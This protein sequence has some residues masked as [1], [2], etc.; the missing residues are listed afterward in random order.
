MSARTLPGIGLTGFWD[1]ETGPWN[2]GMDQNLRKLSALVQSAVLAQVATLPGA[3]D[4][5]AMYLLTDDA[6]SHPGELA[7][8]DA[9]GWTY[10]APREGHRVYDVDAGALLVRTPAGWERVSTTST[11][12]PVKARFATPLLMKAAALAAFAAVAVG[13][14][15]EAGG[16]RYQRAAADATDHHV[17]T[18]AGVKFYVRPMGGKWNPLAFFAPTDGNVADGG[19][20]TGSDASAAFQA[21]FDAAVA[22]AVVAVSSNGN[23][24]AIQFPTG[25]YLVNGL[26]L[27]SSRIRIDATG[28]ELRSFAA[29]DDPEYMLTL[30]GEGFDEGELLTRCGITGLVMEGRRHA[31][32]YGLKISGASHFHFY[33]TNLRGFAGYGLLLENAYDCAFWGGFMT[34]CGVTGTSK[35]D[36]IEGLSIQSTTVDNCNQLYFYTWTFESNYGLDVAI[37]QPSGGSSFY[38]NAISFIGCK[39]EQSAANSVWASVYVPDGFQNSISFED[40]CY[41]AGYHRDGGWLDINLSTSGK[42]TISPST[43]FGY[44]SDQAAGGSTGPT[45]KLRGNGKA[46]IGGKLSDDRAD[47]VPF[48]DTETK[49]GEEIQFSDVSTTNSSTGKA[50]WL[51]KAKDGSSNRV[52]C[53]QGQLRWVFKLTA[54]TAASF[55]PRTESGLLF[56]A[57][58]D[59]S[60]AMGFGGYRCEGGGAATIHALAGG[61]EIEVGTGA[62]TTGAT[63]TASRIHVTVHTDGLVYVKNRQAY[64]VNLYVTL[65]STFAF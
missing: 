44:K 64:S 7:V 1:P 27:N 51:W 65:M 23:Y 61:G 2:I 11:G 36:A 46:L 14:W 45:I 16:F 21:C 4:D 26:T 15:A 5:G 58:H 25:V 49:N 54:D 48:L 20:V 40:K 30:A 62:L 33:Q 57:Q 6:G 10:F 55:F 38:N 3:A 60:Q 59:R 22:A 28:C 41:V 29:K 31:N 24:A 35:T 32:V 43:D 13:G 39:W 8:R 37:R 63:G 42:L 56:I 47:L 53:D 52:I 50:G 19:A 17:A 9:G 12:D 34:F 18:D